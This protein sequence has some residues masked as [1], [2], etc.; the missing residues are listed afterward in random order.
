MWQGYL[1]PIL[2]SHNQLTRLNTVSTMSRLETSPTSTRPAST[3]NFILIPLIGTPGLSAMAPGLPSF[4][5]PGCAAPAVSSLAIAKG[6]KGRDR[7][8]SQVRHL[9]TSRWWQ[10][11]RRRRRKKE[12]IYLPFS[13]VVDSLQA[14]RPNVFLPIQDSFNE[15]ASKVGNKTRRTQDFSRWHCE[16]GNVTASLHSELLLSLPPGP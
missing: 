1:R 5:S 12:G 15:W 8:R 7:W 9:F 13:W 4:P 6:R 3:A 2:S 16:A 14:H 11:S 10:C